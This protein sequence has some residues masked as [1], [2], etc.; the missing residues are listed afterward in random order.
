MGDD[1][2]RD[3]P[4]GLTNGIADR[5]LHRPNARRLA[6]TIFLGTYPDSRLDDRLLQLVH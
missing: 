4:R 1:E 5:L 6:L 3:G 2:P